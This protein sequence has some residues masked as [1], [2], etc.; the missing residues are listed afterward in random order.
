MYIPVHI[1]NCCHLYYLIPAIPRTPEVK[2]ARPDGPQPA[3]AAASVTT[4]PLPPTN[5]GTGTAAQAPNSAANSTAREALPYYGCLLRNELLNGRVQELRPPADA[6]SPN[7]PPKNPLS[8]PVFTYR[9]PSKQ[10]LY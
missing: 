6:R 7:P 4:E 2:K 3:N 1:F 9:S 8:Q 10:V 5:P